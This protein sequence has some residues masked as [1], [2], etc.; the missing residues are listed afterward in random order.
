MSLELFQ[1]TFQTLSFA[2]FIKETDLILTFETKFQVLSNL[3]LC[4]V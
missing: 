1:I 4:Q 2:A 3:C